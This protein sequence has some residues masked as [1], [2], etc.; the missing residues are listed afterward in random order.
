M[1]HTYDYDE[2]QAYIDDANQMRSEAIGEMLNAGWKKIIQFINS[3]TH[4]PSHP[5]AF[6]RRA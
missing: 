1:E 6:I 2:I 4:F 5:P 3:L